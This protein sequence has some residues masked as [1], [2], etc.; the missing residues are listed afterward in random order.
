VFEFDHFNV[1]R[2]R[3]PYSDGTFDLVLCC[4]ILEHLPSDPV[5]LLAEIHRVAL[6]LEGALLL[7]TPNATRTSSLIRILQGDN[8]YEDLSGYG[9]YGRHNREYT[10]RELRDLLNELGFVDIDAFSADIHDE[11]PGVPDLP[12]IE[13]GD[14]GENLF[15]LARPAGSPRY[16]YPR[17]LYS[18]QHAIH[19]VVMPE[20]IAGQNDEVQATGLHP[21]EQLDGDWACWTGAHDAA[22]LTLVSRRRGPAI[23]SIAG[24]GA[25][26][27][28]DGPLAVDVVVGAC[29][30]AHSIPSDGGPLRLRVPVVVPEGEVKVR[31]TTTPTWVP[32]EL[33]INGDRRRLG[34]AISRVSLEHERVAGRRVSFRAYWR[35]RRAR[36]TDGNSRRG[37]PT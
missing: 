34:I 10:V 23:L 37:W 32:A 28:V 21:A 35:E 3:F 27:S 33:G 19:R 1:E 16:R 36:S 15:A 8:P 7:T 14:R 12:G 9:T 31:I 2:D 11:V 18:S 20:V 29:T 22:V 30:S 4:E 24:F 6:P 25:H 26:T 17:W 13:A 5:H